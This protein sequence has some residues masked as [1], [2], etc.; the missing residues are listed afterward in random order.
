METLF[1]ALQLQ[2]LPVYGSTVITRLVCMPD[3]ISDA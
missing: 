2:S 1:T 3:G